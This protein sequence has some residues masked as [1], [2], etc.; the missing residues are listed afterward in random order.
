MSRLPPVAGF[1]WVVA[2]LALAAALYAG[3]R[4][5]PGLDPFVLHAVQVVGTEATAA[6]VVLQ[7]AGIET[8]GSLFGVD[9]ARVRTGVAALPWVREARVVRQLPG[10]L[11]IEV[12][13][14]QPAF[15]ARLD[16]LRYL[17]AA[18]HVVVAP[19]DRGLDFPVITGADR[20]A[21]EGEGPCREALLEW[22]G[23][24]GKGLLDTEVGELHLSPVAG[25]TVYTTDGTGI[26]LGW[27]EYEEKLRRL[28]RLNDH[29][30]RR[31]ES[32]QTV[33]LSYSDRIIAR[34]T[35]AN[36]G[37]RRP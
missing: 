10:T 32:A 1:L 3:S 14:W 5:V 21:I 25:L 22:T 6:E 35:P 7:A 18:G 19:L 34:L 2:S 27:H 20:A 37:K 24:D 16:Q 12:E 36:A 29:L 13:E 31:R 33:N 8:G 15:L 4:A 30:G 9:V 11:R 28:G 26:H 23:L 17:T